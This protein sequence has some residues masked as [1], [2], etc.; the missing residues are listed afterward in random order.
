MKTKIE[1]PE[2]LKYYLRKM[3]DEKSN[4]TERNNY[5][6]ILL[7]IRDDLDTAIKQFEDRK[8]FKK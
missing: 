4:L 5:K 8:I 1:L 7:D 6:E 2:Q 3:A